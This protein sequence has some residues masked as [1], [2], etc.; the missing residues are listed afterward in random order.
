MVDSDYCSGMENTHD[1]TLYHLT[2]N[3]AETI[4]F[5]N[6]KDLS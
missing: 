5:F 3:G 1:R 2:K 6:R 4:R